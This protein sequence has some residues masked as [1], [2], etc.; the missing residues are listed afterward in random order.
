MSRALPL[1]ALLGPAA[2]LGAALFSQYVGGLAPC[3]MCIWQR[4][5]HGV[6]IG[7]AAL[8]LLLGRGRPAALFL[9][10][11]ALALLVG[12]GLGVFHAGVELAWWQGPTECSGAPATG[13]SAADFVERL[14]A[15]PLVRCDV[16]AWSFLGI[17]MA[18]WNAILSAGLA[19]VTLLAARAQASSSAS[20]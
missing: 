3:Q 17:S 11:G 16:V 7:L 18:G 6:A 9:F 2:V 1:V 14:R 4:W 12:S 15:A 5:P 10:L 8:A 13:L 19:G 20:Q